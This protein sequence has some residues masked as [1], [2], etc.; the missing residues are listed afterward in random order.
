MAMTANRASSNETP[1]A[2][3]LESF[4]R[5]LQVYGDLAGSEAITRAL[6]AERTGD[7][8]GAIFWLDVFSEVVRDQARQTI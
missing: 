3:N 7:R 1:T 8:A 2:E 5:A 6:V 4:V